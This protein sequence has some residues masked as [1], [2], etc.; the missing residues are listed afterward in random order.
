[1][2]TRLSENKLLSEVSTFG[3]G[4]PAKFFAVAKTAE[5]MQELLQYAHQELLPFHIVGK[6]SNS[7]FDDRGFDGLVIQNQIDFI[8][9]CGE[10]VF[11][12]GGGANFSLL[13]VKTARTGWSGLEFASGIPASV[14]G[15]IFMNAGANGTETAEALVS[16]D[17]VDEKGV[18]N[19]FLKSELSFSY[20]SSSFHQMLGA[21]VGAKFQLKKA[22]DARTKQLDII[23]YRQ[24]TQPYGEKSAGCVFRNP[25]EGSAGRMI[26]GCALKGLHVGGAVVSE[27]HANFIINR[28]EAKAK[29][30]LE[31]IEKVRERV[32]EETGVK[33]ESE[34]RYVPYRF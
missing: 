20:R 5:E 29:E 23:R 33:L 16:V 26:E 6:G 3:I 9:D 18:L 22:S 4:G 7:L 21:I 1:M 14:G 27:K 25:P 19:T 17:F 28:K 2:Q 11:S 32:K 10:G 31:L 30:V 12:V 8:E 13:G 15:A 24:Q 34:V